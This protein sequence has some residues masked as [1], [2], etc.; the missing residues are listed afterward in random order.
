MKDKIILRDCF[1]SWQIDG[2]FSHLFPPNGD[3]DI[4]NNDYN[5]YLDLDYLG[6]YSGEKTISNLVRLLLD[7]NKKLTN[8]ALDRLSDIIHSLY[9]DKWSGLWATQNLE[10]NPIENYNM[11]E[12]LTN[13]ST[14][15]NYGHTNTRTDNLTHAKTGTETESPNLTVNDN[16]GVNGFN[17]NDSVPAEERSRTSTGNTQTTYNTSDADTGTQTTVDSGADTTTHSYLLTRD[18]NIGT[19]TAQDMI[20]QERGLWLNWD[21]FRSVVYPDIDRVLTIYTY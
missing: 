20:E 13:D 3:D 12:R 10:Y 21:F 2:I 16:L 6:N 9:N 17:S 1:T 5:Q 11:R 15:K 7:E 8:A 19:V 18:G 4:W 14:V